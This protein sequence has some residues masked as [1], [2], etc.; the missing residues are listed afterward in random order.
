MMQSEWIRRL[1]LVDR[2]RI[3]S[4]LKS[5]LSP[6][7]WIVLPMNEDLDAIMLSLGF[8]VESTF[9]NRQTMYRFEAESDADQSVQH[10]TASE[11]IQLL[12]DC[13]GSENNE[14]E[15]GR[16]E[17]ERMKKN[18]EEAERVLRMSEE[19]RKRLLELAA[20]DKDEEFLRE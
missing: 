14:F 12:V 9:G 4:A 6:G 20:L 3:S 16:L 15:E 19:K 17:Q 1:S 5:G 10:M 13:F 2:V 11:R 8:A 18:I 7:D